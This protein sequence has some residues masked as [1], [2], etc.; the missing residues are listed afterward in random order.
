MEI[1]LIKLIKIGI[2][3]QNQESEENKQKDVLEQF[4]WKFQS[5]EELRG[6]LREFFFSMQGY[7][8][9]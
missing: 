7:A 2:N 4:G 5:H 3:I 1:Q 8:N 6:T 9:L